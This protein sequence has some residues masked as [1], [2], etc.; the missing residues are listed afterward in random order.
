MP[1]ALSLLSREGRPAP[2]QDGSIAAGEII[3]STSQGPR[4]RFHRLLPSLIVAAVPFVLIGNALWLLVTPGFV[5]ILY[6][7]L[8]I[9]GPIESLSASGARGLGMDGIW[10]VHPGGEGVELLRRARLQDGST[11][12]TE[13]EVRHMADVRSVVGGAYAAWAIAVVAA[14]I[15]AFA[16]RRSGRATAVRRALRD[17]AGLTVAATLLLAL[18]MA[19]SFGVVFE[20]FH[21]VFF[22]GDSWRFP[23]DSLLLKLYPESFWTAA[24]ATAA[25][26]IAL[27]AI[28]IR[29]GTRVGT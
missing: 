22:A 29:L 21:G 10:S 13:R 12:F 6:G 20:A 3:A 16:L 24:G 19:L 23:S 8:G 26:L 25:A 17:G 15:A 5:G 7:L 28:G 27:Q 4:H 2:C 18:A 9:P 11:A 1:R 14:A